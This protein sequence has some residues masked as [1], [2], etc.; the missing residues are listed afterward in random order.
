M[1]RSLRFL[2]LLTLVVLASSQTSRAETVRVPATGEP[3]FAFDAPSGW[4]II[5]DQYGNA[6]FVANDHASTMQLMIITDA[7]AMSTTEMAVSFF[8]A[9]DASPYSRTGS[10]TIAG[11]TADVFY[12]DLVIDDTHLNMAIMIHKIDDSHVAILSTTTKA[13]ILPAQTSALEALTASVRLT[14]VK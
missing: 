6:E 7:G 10:G 1:V 2:L 5:Y 3:A 13:D 12:S 9:A 4:M 14:G 8:Q 11:Y